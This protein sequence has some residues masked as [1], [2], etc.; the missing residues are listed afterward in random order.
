MFDSF[1]LIFTNGGLKPTSQQLGIQD[2]QDAVAEMARCCCPSTFVEEEGT[3]HLGW[4][5]RDHGERLPLKFRGTVKTSN[6][7]WQNFLFQIWEAKPNCPTQLQLQ[8]SPKHPDISSQV[9]HMNHGRTWSG[10]HYQWSLL[11][12]FYIEQLPPWISW[13]Y[14]VHAV[15]DCTSH[16]IAFAMVRHLEMIVWLVGMKVHD[17]DSSIQSV[18][19]A[20][21]PKPTWLQF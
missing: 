8:S 7:F 6:D 11:W 20:C 1:D 9:I 17:I 19:V 4:E 15:L 14:H 18:V 5:K 10:S 16:G 3:S 12:P 21:D 2:F 13:W